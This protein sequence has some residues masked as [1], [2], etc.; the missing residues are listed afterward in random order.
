MKG[1]G[2]RGK[3]EHICTEYDQVLALPE[4]AQ[5]WFKDQ[6]LLAKMD[7]SKILKKIMFSDRNVFIYFLKQQKYFLL[8]IVESD[9]LKLFLQAKIFNA[10]TDFLY[11]F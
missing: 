5:I 1:K 3:P 4:Y 2:S 10:E 6:Q 11:I 8:F 9:F 7:S